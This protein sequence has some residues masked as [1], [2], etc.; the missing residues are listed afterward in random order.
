MRRAS[1][2]PGREQFKSTLD[3]RHGEIGKMLPPT[4][5]AAAPP[6]VSRAKRAPRGF[7]NPLGA[8]PRR[9]ANH[10]IEPVAPD[11]RCRECRLDGKWSGRR[12]ARQA[13]PLATYVAA[14]DTKAAD[15]T[16]ALG[17]ESRPVPEERRSAAPFEH[18][19]DPAGD[20][21]FPLHQRAENCVSFR[22]PDLGHCSPLRGAVRVAQRAMMAADPPRRR[23]SERMAEQRIDE[24]IARA[25]G[26]VEVRQRWQATRRAATHRAQHFEPEPEFGEPHRTGMAVDAE[27]TSGDKVTDAYRIARSRTVQPSREPRPE[28]PPTLPPDQEP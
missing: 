3:K 25:H 22:A 27:E 20:R 6:S 16:P 12:I 11:Q 18:C 26:G 15:F 28:T 9:I 2:P 19:A 14:R 7:G 13:P 1:V 23:T 24:R 5:A 4:G 17:V 21:L 10:E 8:H